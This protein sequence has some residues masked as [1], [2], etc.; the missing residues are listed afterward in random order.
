MKGTLAS[1]ASND[2]MA[3]RLPMRHIHSARLI[4]R[5]YSCIGSGS[6]PI[7]HVIRVGDVPPRGWVAIPH[8]V[9]VVR[10]VAH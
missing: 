1:E 10:L 7:V 3:T 4:L 8:V 9:L 2:R 6:G 5:V